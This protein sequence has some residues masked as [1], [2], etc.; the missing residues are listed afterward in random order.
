MNIEI[1]GSSVKACVDKKG[2]RCVGCLGA[3]GF[4]HS[5]LKSY[6]ECETDFV[7]GSKWCEGNECL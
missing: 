1:K 2:A 6:E 3:D 7:S 5:K 4:C